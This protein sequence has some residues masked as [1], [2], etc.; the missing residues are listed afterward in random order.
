MEQMPDQPAFWV[1]IQGLRG[2]SF[3]FARLV[4]GSLEMRRGTLFEA[5]RTAHIF[6][7]PVHVAGTRSFVAKISFSDSDSA[8]P[9]VPLASPPVGELLDFMTFDS[10]VPAHAKCVFVV[11]DAT[12]APAPGE[13]GSSA[14]AM[15]TC[16]AV[17]A[18]DYFAELD[19]GTGSL[20]RSMLACGAAVLEE[21]HPLWLGLRGGDPVAAF[22][23]R[24]FM[25]AGGAGVKQQISGLGAA[26]PSSHYYGSS[27]SSSAAGP[28][29]SVSG[30]WQQRHSHL[31]RLLDKAAAY[32]TA[33]MLRAF[34]TPSETDAESAASSSESPA[35]SNTA[36]ADGVAA[37]A[38]TACEPAA[39]A[40][41]RFYSRPP[42][43]F[44][45]V[46][47]P[48]TGF[49]V[50]CEWVGGLLLSVFSQPFMLGGLRHAAAVDSIM[51]QHWQSASLDS[52][53][54]GFSESIDLGPLLQRRVWTA[55]DARTV[56]CTRQPVRVDGSGI[57]H[58][59]LFV[60]V[61]HWNGCEAAY[62]KRSARAYA[63]YATAYEAALAR[64][65]AAALT[66]T[67][68]VAEPPPAALLPAQMLYGAGQVAV[69][70]PFI[71]GGRHPADSELRSLHEDSLV[72]AALADAVVWLALHD[73]LYTDFRPPNI[74][75]MTTEATM[76]SRLPEAAAAAGGAGSLW[77]G[78]S[79]STA[80][81]SL[82]PHAASARPETA[83]SLPAAHAGVTSSSAADVRCG[84]AGAASTASSAGARTCPG[85]HFEDHDD[86]LYVQVLPLPHTTVPSSTRPGAA[87]GSASLSGSAYRLA[88]SSMFAG[89]L[90]L[91]SSD[92]SA[93][94]CADCGAGA[95][96]TALAPSISA[97]PRASP[98]YLVD[99]DD[100]RVVP[101]LGDSLR[102][103][104]GVAAIGAAYSRPT[105]EGTGY[106]SRF[107]GSEYPG[108]T[109]AVEKRLA[110][111]SHAGAASTPRPA[112]GPAS[113]HSLASGLASSEVAAA[114]AGAETAVHSK[115]SLLAPPIATAAQAG[116]PEAGL[117]G[118]SA[119]GV[120]AV[121]DFVGRL[122]IAARDSESKLRGLSG[123][124]EQLRATL[125]IGCQARR[126][127]EVAAS[128]VKR[129]GAA[130]PP[131]PE[132]IAKLARC[133]SAVDDI[134]GCLHG[135][136][137]ETGTLGSQLLP[138]F[139]AEATAAT[140]GVG[141]KRHAALLQS[142]KT[143]HAPCDKQA[144][145]IGPPAKRRL[146]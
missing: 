15:E 11:L 79:A 103:R 108:L 71:H 75:I 142:G 111:L 106:E 139:A 131:E 19:V 42:L 18:V 35:T 13:S 112:G 145:G 134:A 47:A 44:A 104:G 107:I 46:G 23:F 115:R 7:E 128:D 98:V 32:V 119:H 94:S 77:P 99:Y 51:I 26:A 146:G 129:T 31:R 96:A 92:A 124:L 30:D 84:S 6:P 20:R 86:G 9:A 121:H 54:G 74:I 82:A 69:L 49:L 45:V 5:V 12:P 65:G 83:Q 22:E 56:F 25:S 133:I 38:A 33:D 76:A 73:L 16:A 57:D 62:F 135:L 58:A 52:G 123:E 118:R 37:S 90:G 63:A 67:A 59:D 72:A 114:I 8:A 66:G 137:V 3:P 93:D 40:Q 89:Q 29:A 64:S 4:S 50:A 138:D 48:P 1:A 78:M 43:S 88:L 126:L 101:G 144:T 116:P 113:S 102:A 120:A 127:S 91:P 17:P 36:S 100:M 136:A 28:S 132:V 21:H 109:K 60:K 10:L 85:S 2:R 117:L 125:G 95:A 61:R 140:A 39:Y 55:N 70:M 68:R 105:D 14:T 81:P 97:V 27:S 141:A 41:S 87:S 122:G 80:G 24:G 110:A 53:L 34:F 143:T 130:I